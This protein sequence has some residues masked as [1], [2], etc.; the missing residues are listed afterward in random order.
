MA[1]K[2]HWT[3]PGAHFGGDPEFFTAWTLFD[4]GLDS[5][6][7]RENLQRFIDLVSMRGQP[8]LSGVEMTPEQDIT[9][10]LFGKNIT[11]KHTVWSYK[12]IVDKVGLM[13]EHSLLVEA[14]GL[15]MITGLNETAALG[16]KII[17]QGDDANTFFIRHESL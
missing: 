11:G 1:D 4:I 16:D 5:E 3:I 14:N 13:N 8:I 2:K 12:W 17:T 9:D 10:G 15:P 6:S 7:S